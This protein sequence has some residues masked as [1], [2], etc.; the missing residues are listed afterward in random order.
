MNLVTKPW[1]PILRLDGKTDLASLQQIFK[2]GNQ[3]ADLAVRPHERIALMRLLIC[4]AQVALD[5]PE[6]IDEWDNAPQTL[7]KAASS[8]LDEKKGLFELF[9]NE[10]PFLQIAELERVSDQTTF[11]SKMEFNLSSKTGQDLFDHGLRTYGSY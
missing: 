4:I 9:D 5:G 8:Y 11:V 1:I 2:E 7:P 10:K 6:N 3:Y